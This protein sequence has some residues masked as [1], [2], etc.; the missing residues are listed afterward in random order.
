SNRRDRLLPILTADLRDEEPTQSQL[1]HLQTRASQ[2]PVAHRPPFADAV[3]QRHGS[4]RTRRPDRLL[5]ERL[6]LAKR[7]HVET[8]LPGELAYGQCWGGVLL[9]RDLTSRDTGY[10]F[11]LGGESSV[12]YRARG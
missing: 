11:Q 5:P 4:V 2:C 7:S 9:H 10:T 12:L 8:R 1:A 3:G 6:V